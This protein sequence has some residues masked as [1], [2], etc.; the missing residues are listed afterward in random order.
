MHSVVRAGRRSAHGLTHASRYSPPRPERA[1]NGRISSGSATIDDDDAMPDWFRFDFG[2]SW[3]YTLG[4]LSVFVIASAVAAVAFWRGARTWV[5]AVAVLLAVWG[6]AG[7]ATMHYAIQINA[8]T[9]V[10]TATFLPA[11]AGH[12]LD[13]GAGSGRATVGL[14][15][16]RP[17]ARVTALD[18]YRGYY[19]IDDNTADRLRH[20][21]R[22]AGVGDRVDVQEADMR[23]LPFEADRFD[24][25]MSVAAIDHLRWPD[26]ERAMRETA[27][28]LKPRGQFL[29]VSLNSD[30]WVRLAIPAALHGTG[31]WGSRQASERWREA[32]ERNGYDVVEAGTA[33]ATAYVLAAKR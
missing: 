24:A 31:F 19:G 29:V 12:V 14:L 5:T 20:N 9:R 26:I 10:P 2:Y 28:V 15:L 32:F 4:H 22:V 21:A 23:Q 13:L 17:Q 30:V 33:P 11:G 25:A 1:L 16:A 18:A 7:T 8:P 6:L 27:R 3:P